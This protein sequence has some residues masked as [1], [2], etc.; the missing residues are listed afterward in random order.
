RSRRLL[1]Q[2]RFRWIGRHDNDDRHLWIKRFELIEEF[3]RTENCGLGF[4]AASLIKDIR[5]G[6][7]WLNCCDAGLA[8][9]A[10][11]TIH[12]RNVAHAWFI[13]TLLRREWRRVACLP[14]SAHRGDLDTAAAPRLSSVSSNF[15]RER[16]FC[17]KINSPRAGY[18]R[19]VA[20]Q[21]NGAHVQ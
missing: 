21:Q 14:A 6:E 8:G 7:V 9:V 18:W 3:D 5:E 2:H 10:L 1:A 12:R 17:G 16:A 20:S 11:S 4:T 15:A 13:C 19:V